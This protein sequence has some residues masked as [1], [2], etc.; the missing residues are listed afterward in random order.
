MKRATLAVLSGLCVAALA[1][2]AKAVGLILSWSDSGSDA[3]TAA[4]PVSTQRE[5]NAGGV[6]VPF[7]EDVF[8]FTDRNHQYNGARFT[9]AGVL[10]NT[11]PAVAGDVTVPIPAYL[12]GGEY[13]STFNNNRDNAAY[14][15]N[16]VVGPAVQAYL[17]IDNRVGETTT[18]AFDPPTL[19]TGASQMN[20][21]LTDGWQVVNTGISPNGQRDF[22]ALDEGSTPA[23]FASRP[24]ANANLGVGPGVLIN[25]FYSIYTKSFPA[26]STIT[27][28]EQNSGGINMYGLVVQPAVPE[29]ASVLSLAAVGAIGLL[30]RRR[31]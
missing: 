31:A 8:A 7:G 4:F 13:M 19:G 11:N 16:V 28:K 26:G 6:L 3:T 29:P 24:A 1:M 21:V 17:L 20:W 2:E 10:T 18:N 25:N 23:D 12:L 15:M 30:R 14:V 9:S 5:N 27:L 22:I